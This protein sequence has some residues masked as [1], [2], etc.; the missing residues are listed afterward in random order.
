MLSSDLLFQRKKGSQPSKK[1]STPSPAARS[2]GAS[3]KTKSKVL[4]RRFR[5]ACVWNLKTVAFTPEPW[6]QRMS[7]RDIVVRE[8]F[9]RARCR[10]VEISCGKIF[11]EDVEKCLEGE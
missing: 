2:K 8:Q 9:V 10:D 5:R 4:E 1:G 6:R 11:E 7:G 3:R